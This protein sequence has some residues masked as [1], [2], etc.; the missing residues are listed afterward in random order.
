M[1][2][3]DTEAEDVAPV[4]TAAAILGI[5]VADLNALGNGETTEGS[6]LSSTE[7]IDGSG[8]IEFDYRFT[9]DDY[10]PYMDYS[11]FVLDGTIHELANVGDIDT[12]A[13]IDSTG[14]QTFSIYVEEGGLY[15]VGFGVFDEGDSSVFSTLE[16]DNIRFTPDNLD[17]P[18]VFLS[19]LSIDV[20]PLATHPGDT[21]YGF[22]STEPG[23]EFDFASNQNPDVV[24][25]D[26][27]GNDTL[28]LSG[29]VAASAIDLKPGAFSSA[30]GQTDNIQIALGTDIENAI[31]GAGDDTLRGND[32]A[33]R[34]DGGIGLDTLTG[35]GGADVFVLSLT[36]AAD[37]ITDFDLGADRLDISALLDA[38][39]TPG[40]LL[41]YIDAETNP[42]GDISISVDQD[43]AGTTHGYE[44]VAILQGA[45]SGG[46]IDFVFQDNGVQVTET[47]AA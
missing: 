19:E 22:N 28:D 35:G 36:D 47:F 41:N 24:I 42:A 18:E 16:I 15:S 5:A 39:F 34:L 38:N 40:D 7:Y 23:T 29:Y 2:L 11:V 13:D 21:V 25:E 14:W 46:V 12:V 43:G 37:I 44:E 26:T 30:N 4:S 20:E 27:S 31:G 3:L 33:N 8:T 1:L 6:V 9:T 32:L 17:P 10:V 45:S